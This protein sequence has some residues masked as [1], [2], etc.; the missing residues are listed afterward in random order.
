VNSL[1][2]SAEIIF[3]NS[4]RAATLCRDAFRHNVE[5]IYSIPPRSDGNSDFIC[6]AQSSY[7]ENGCGVDCDWIF[8]H[9]KSID[10]VYKLGKANNCITL[11]LEDERVRRVDHPFVEALVIWLRRVRKDI[12]TLATKVRLAKS[13]L[14]KEEFAN[15][16]I[17]DALRKIKNVALAIFEKKDIE[18][19]YLKDARNTSGSEFSGAYPYDRIQ[20]D[21]QRWDSLSDNGQRLLLAFCNESKT[22][23]NGLEL[24]RP[25]YA[26][27]FNSGKDFVSTFLTRLKKLVKE[28]A[29]QEEPLLQPDASR[30]NSAKRLA[31]IFAARQSSRPY[32]HKAADFYDLVEITGQLQ[33]LSN[34][35]KELVPN[36]E[37]VEKL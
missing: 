3:K 37:I 6:E 25:E 14:V 30:L 16:G 28:L 24:T 9:Q 27:P 33:H 20:L 17:I 2:T 5:Q 21:E 23:I 36:S 18:E 29:A 34:M 1:A 31:N 8:W 19:N 7:S 15:Q 13:P 35:A 12:E 22:H 26:A 32:S 11:T 10:I 4:D